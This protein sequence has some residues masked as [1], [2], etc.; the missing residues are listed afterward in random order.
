MVAGRG[1][2]EL[3]ALGLMIVCT[4]CWVTPLSV[5][6]Q[7]AWRFS[8]CSFL[9]SYGKPT[10]KAERSRVKQQGSDVDTDDKAHGY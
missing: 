7:T 8:D 3:E 9:S 1:K 5:L 2:N 4:N 10:A 6:A